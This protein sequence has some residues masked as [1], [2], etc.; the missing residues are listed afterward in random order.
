MFPG[1]L[2]PLHFCA[3]IETAPIMSFV[4]SRT[5]SHSLTLGDV[6]L[7][8]VQSSGYPSYPLP[9]ADC[10]RML[11]IEACGF[12]IENRDYARPMLIFHPGQ[13]LRADRMSSRPRRSGIVAESRP[14]GATLMIVVHKFPPWIC[15]SVDFIS[16]KSNKIIIIDE[17]NNYFSLYF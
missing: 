13:Q 11:L 1:L 14:Q 2:C 16:R 12:L 7:E 17:Q 6:F 3:V 5:R 15:D 10:V 4:C 9:H 8:N